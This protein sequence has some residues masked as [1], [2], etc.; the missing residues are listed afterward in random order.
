MI[1]YVWGIY[2]GNPDLKVFYP[3]PGT[4]WWPIYYLESTTA[5]PRMGKTQFP[6]LLAVT[7]DPAERDRYLDEL[8]GSYAQVTWFNHPVRMRD[9]QIV[10]TREGQSLVN[11]GLHYDPIGSC[12]IEVPL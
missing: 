1:C 12:I 5:D 7:T 10:R 6:E 2:M 9:G 11:P 8:P 3:C 4:D